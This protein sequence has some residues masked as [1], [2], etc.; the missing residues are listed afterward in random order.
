MGIQAL[1][2]SS[3]T[4]SQEE[5]PFSFASIYECNLD[6]L[7]HEVNQKK[8]ILERTVTSGTQKPSNIVELSKIIEPFKEVFHKLFRLCKIAIAIPVRTASC[9]CRFSTLKLVKIYDG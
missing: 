1:N 2:P 4:F 3:A 7:R 9:E 6:D 5:A 8:R